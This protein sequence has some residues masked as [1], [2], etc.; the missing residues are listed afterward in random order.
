MK[1]GRRSLLLLLMAVTLCYSSL[2]SSSARAEVSTGSD[3]VLGRSTPSLLVDDLNDEPLT[4]GETFAFQAEVSRLMDILINSLYR[5]KEIFLREL[6]SNASDALDKIRFLALSNNELLGKLRDLEIRISFDKDAG[7]LTIRDTGVGMTKDDLVNNLGTV[8]KSGTANF[9][10]AM[11]AGA[12]DSSLIGQFGVGF[13]SVYLVA[14]RVRVVS[15]NNND[16]QYIWESDANASFT[17]TKDPRGDTLGRGTEITLFLK[18]DATEFQDQDKLKN[19]VGH[20]SEFITFPI[21]VN[22]TSTETYEVEEEPA[23]VEEVVEEE[24]DEEKPSEEDEELEAVEE[25]DVKTPKTRAETRTVWKW[26]RVNEVKAIWTRSK[27]EISDEEYESFYH[28]LQKTDITD[29]LTWIHFQAEGEIEFKSILYVPGQAPRDLYTRFENKKADIKLYVRKVLITDD[30]DDFLP[31]YLNFI[32]GVVDSDDLPINVSRETLQENK[33]LRVIRKKLVRKVLE[34]LRK[35]AEKDED[36]DEE[37]EEDDEVV[38]TSADESNDKKETEGDAEKEEEEEEEDSNTAY[39]KFW[40]EFGKNIKLGVMDDAANR[41]KLVKLLR[42]VTSESD[43]KW[44]SLEQYVD[45]MKD[46]QDS[47]YYIAAENADACEKSPFME[48]MRA[49]GLEVLYFVDALDEYMVSHISEFDGK[50]LVSITK[51]GIKFGD[52]DESLTQKREQLYAD[53]Y[54]ALT[55][56][57]K[58]LYGDKISRVTMS[59]RV[60]DSPA[61]MVTSQWGYSANMQRIMKAQ[62]FGNGDKNSPMYGTG[63]AILEL[64]PRHPIVSKLNE[65]M[66]SDPEK[67]ETK[68]LAWLLYDTALINSGFDMTDTTQFSTRVHR[69]MKSSMGIDSLELEPEIEVPEEEQE[70]DEEEEAEDLD[71]S[72][73]QAEATEEADEPVV[74]GKDEL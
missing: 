65:L 63:S 38:D 25:E 15:K 1:G 12:D 62:T 41:A 21:Y 14:D 61:V 6:I 16:D 72:E 49:K 58:T 18:P 4:G 3:E 47:I 24:T 7:T 56:A 64:N 48:K 37:D 40:E 31:R 73:A 50:K 8:A 45:R 74:D 35:L 27:D 9:V 39:N 46:W 71:E 55:T 17:I 32:A 30:F 36:D 2:S 22:T 19:L 29:P 44:T 68:D 54:V 51:E 57:L 69:I 42:F 33:I 26:E 66:V 28:S 43:G 59:Q 10:E 70:V 11:Q 67:E 60:V 5:T 23:D 20:Y 34:M 53:K 13:Y 52:E